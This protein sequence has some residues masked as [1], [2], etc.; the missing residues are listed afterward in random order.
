[1]WETVV[2]IVI[3]GIAL[4]VTG[5]SLV[6][7]LRGEERARPCAC[8]GTTGCHGSSACDEAGTEDPKGNQAPTD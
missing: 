8:G 7:R 2:A 5:Y 6:Q 1:M 3:V 4:V